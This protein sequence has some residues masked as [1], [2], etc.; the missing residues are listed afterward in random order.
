[1]IS[2]FFRHLKRKLQSIAARRTA[3][4]CF[5][6]CYQR[7]QA[8]NATGRGSDSSP[9]AALAT[10]PRN[11]QSPHL[12]YLRFIGQRPSTFPS[13]SQSQCII[14]CTCPYRTPASLPT[15]RPPLQAF[16][17]STASHPNLFKLLFI[18][19][20]TGPHQSVSGI[21]H[22]IQLSHLALPVS[23]SSAWGA[24]GEAQDAFRDQDNGMLFRTVGCF[25]FLRPSL[26]RWLDSV[27]LKP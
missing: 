26:G 12:L 2:R 27:W 15:Q 3:D 11:G 10:L 20:A 24:R 18:P 16:V 23:R 4:E 9:L 25:L 6:G 14:A 5:L 8:R 21:H 22:T 19:H 7:P 1:M 17:T 13:R